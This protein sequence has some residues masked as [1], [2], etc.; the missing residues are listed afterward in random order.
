MLPGSNRVFLHLCGIR[1]IVTPHQTHLRDPQPSRAAIP[2]DGKREQA[3]RERDFVR[4]ARWVG[5]RIGREEPNRRLVCAAL[6]V[7]RP[8]DLQSLFVAQDVVARAGRDTR[9]FRSVRVGREDAELDV[10]R[11]Q[12]AGERY[13]AGPVQEAFLERGLC[14]GHFVGD[15]RCDFLWRWRLAEK[16]DASRGR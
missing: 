14:R 12:R 2:R 10:A 13:D 16:V 8:L 15:K 5:F 1:E 7:G 11:R 9:P 3:V 6:A 4:L